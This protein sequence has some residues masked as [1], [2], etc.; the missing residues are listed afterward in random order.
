MPSPKKLDDLLL[1]EMSRRNTDL[2]AGLV[3]QKPELFIEL[4]SLYADNKEPVSRRAAWVIDTVSEKNPE[5]LAPYLNDLVRLLP[6]FRHD[7]LKRH[8]LRML[9]RSPLPCDTLLGELVNIC[10]EWFSS[11]NQAAAIRV[12]CMEIL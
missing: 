2:I 9:A 1:T 8:A 6:L 5:L 4:F 11:P 3:V 12:Y 10:F 7:G